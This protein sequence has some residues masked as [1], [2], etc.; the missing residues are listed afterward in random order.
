MLQLSL[1]ISELSFEWSLNI[2][3]DFELCLNNML[4]VKKKFTG[5]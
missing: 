4:N 1:I 3:I 5:F 2:L